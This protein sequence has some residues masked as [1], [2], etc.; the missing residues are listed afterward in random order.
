MVAMLGDVG[1]IFITYLVSTSVW[2]GD[3]RSIWITEEHKLHVIGIAKYAHRAAPLQMVNFLVP[4]LIN[5][6]RPFFGK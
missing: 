4:F 1:G 5:L 2:K 6:N 3:R